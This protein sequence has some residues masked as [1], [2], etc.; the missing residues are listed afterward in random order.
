MIKRA[1][2]ILF[3]LISL[4][5]DVLYAQQTGS[6]VLLPFEIN[7]QEDLSYLQKEIPTAIKKQLN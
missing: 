4:L 1:C 5:A 6:V 2:L 7:A 3:V